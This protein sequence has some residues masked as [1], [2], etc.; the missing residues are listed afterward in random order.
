[1]STLQLFKAPWRKLGLSALVVA[2]Y[3]FFWINGPLQEPQPVF[4]FTE[5]VTGFDA[6][7]RVG[8]E[9]APPIFGV[10]EAQE[11]APYHAVI[12]VR[13]KKPRNA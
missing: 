3:A 9:K 13:E 5:T 1:M 2:A 6:P 8:E 10:V 4:E 12:L 11:K 7:V